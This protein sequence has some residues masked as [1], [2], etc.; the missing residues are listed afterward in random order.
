MSYLIPTPTGAQYRPVINRCRRVVRLWLYLAALATTGALA[1]AALGLAG[2]YAQGGIATMQHGLQTGSAVA[3]GA[4]VLPLAGP[5]ALSLLVAGTTD[6]TG[7]D[8]D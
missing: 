7:G 8:D 3:V 6:K 2:A 5:G 4:G 1:A